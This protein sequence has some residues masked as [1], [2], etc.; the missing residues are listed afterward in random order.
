VEVRIKELTK[1]EIATLIELAEKNKPVTKSE[2]KNYVSSLT[3]YFITSS[4]ARK[5]LI[6]NDGIRGQ[7]KVWK[8]TEKGK[9]VASLLKQLEQVLVW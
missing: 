2:L 7:F 8:L 3:W 5:G 4:L 1:N 9:K 6:Q